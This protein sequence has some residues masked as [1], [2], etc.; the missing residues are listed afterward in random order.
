MLV[1]ITDAAARLSALGDVVDRSTLSRYLKQHAE[2]LP[3]TRSGKSSLV[4][5]DDLLAHRSENIRVAG[6]VGDT[7][8]SAPPS[9][10][11]RVRSDASAGRTRF[12]GS[13][14]DGAARKIHAEAEMRELDLAE[15]RGEL[16]PK[17]EVDRAGREAVA[18]MSASF[19]RAVETAAAQA[20][21]KYG[22]DERTVRLVLKGYARD[23]L[24]VFHRELLDRIEALGAKSGAETGDIE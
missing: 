4:E 16:V 11:Q 12:S 14:A 23:G 19:E 3:L 10:G 22:W 13:Q 8:P 5:W 20:S 6:P 9:A 24:G 2:A 18:L 1:S 7:A 21:I 17:S 15:R